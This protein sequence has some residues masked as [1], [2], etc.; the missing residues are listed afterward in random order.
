MPHPQRAGHVDAT[1]S[2]QIDALNAATDERLDAA[3]T[4]EDAFAAFEEFGGAFVRIVTE[5][6]DDL[7]ALEPPAALRADHAAT[8][9]NL[10]RRVEFAQALA[11][12]AEKE[13]LDADDE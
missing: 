8:V 10:R 13:D 2:L 3:E 9:A 11:D 5:A 6:T 12:A 1:T 7:E 4:D